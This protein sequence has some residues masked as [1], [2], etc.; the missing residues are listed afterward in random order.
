MANLDAFVNRTKPLPVSLSTSQEI[1]DRASTFVGNIYRAR[2][3]AEA[4][5]AI[6]YLSRVVHGSKPASHEIAAWRCM[7]LK[8]GKTGLDGEDDFEVIEGSEDDGEGRAGARVLKA[9]QTEAVMDAVVIVSRW[10]GGTMLG[11]IRF[12]HIETCARDVCRAVRLQDELE[13]LLATLSSLD[14]ILENLRSE[15]EKV[16]SAS[17]MTVDDAAAPSGSQRR[18]RKPQDYSVIRKAVDIAKAKRL[19]TA[20]ENAIKNM[21]TLITKAKEKA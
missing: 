16:K 17:P 10:Y 13:D 12:E 8:A 18:V 7:S 6:N 5:A 14:D 1:R 20:R 11:P 4:R 3:L 15:L 19:V 9:M 2:T 21:K